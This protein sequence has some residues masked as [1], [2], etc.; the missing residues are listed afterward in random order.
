[1]DLSEINAENAEQ[2]AM[3]L[4]KLSIA[5]GQGVNTVDKMAR[6]RWSAVMANQDQYEFLMAVKDD[7]VRALRV[8]AA[9]SETLGNYV[10]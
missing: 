7:F 9:L 2:I 5:I 1:M 6:F 4:Y 3:E 8:L 10:F